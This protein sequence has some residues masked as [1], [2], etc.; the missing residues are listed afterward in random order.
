[1]TQSERWVSREAE[2]KTLRATV[3][4]QSLMPK[5]KIREVTVSSMHTEATP[6]HVENSTL[7]V[8]Q[9]FRTV[10]AMF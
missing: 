2:A 5:L 3:R 9:S 6:W 1:M 7:N 4:S 10:M 8:G